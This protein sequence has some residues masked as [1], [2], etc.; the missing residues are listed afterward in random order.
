MN[1][2]RKVII[3]KLIPYFRKDSRYYLLVGDM[4]FSAID[5]LKS[6]FPKRVFNCGVMEQGM[7]GIAAGMSMSGLV[8]IVYSI[9]NFLAF[10]SLEQT[11]N[12]VVL[13]KLNVKFIGTGANNYFKFLGES[14]Y[15]G[16]DDIKIMQ[17]I[18]MRVYDPYTSPK[19][20]DDLVEEWIRD[21]RAGYIRV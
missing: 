8:P 11:R 13:Q 21:E 19:S 4:G 1:N 20:F 18:N 15:C 14:H 17:L 5:Q 3:D 16:D 9:L 2:Y 12:D 6:E 10:R 7:V